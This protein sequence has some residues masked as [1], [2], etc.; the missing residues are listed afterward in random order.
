ELLEIEDEPLET[1]RDARLG[2]AFGREVANQ[3]TDLGHHQPGVVA[4]LFELRVDRRGAG[5]SMQTPVKLEPD[6]KRQ[7]TECVVQVVRDPNAVV[8]AYRLG[9]LSVQAR[10][11]ERERR[12]VCRRPK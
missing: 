10:V 5:R 3:L 7:L 2:Q 12:V 8:H 1:A 9:R 6:R 4:K 11:L